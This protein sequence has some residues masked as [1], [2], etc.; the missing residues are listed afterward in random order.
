MYTRKITKLR[1]HYLNFFHI[2]VFQYLK[3]NSVH[4]ILNKVLQQIMVKMQLSNAG[5]IYSKDNKIKMSISQFY[6]INVY[7]I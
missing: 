3:I 5:Q 1:C 2:Y 7:D 6:P 4:L